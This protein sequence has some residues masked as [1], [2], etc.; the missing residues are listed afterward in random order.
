M[1]VRR[2]SQLLATAVFAVAFVAFASLDGGSVAKAQG[3]Y[4]DQYR[5]HRNYDYGRNYLDRYQRQERREFR[6]RQQ[7]ERYLYGNPPA[8]RYYQ[9]RNPWGFGGYPRSGRFG[10]YGGFGRFGAYPRW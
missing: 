9:R 1:L 5:D 10:F 8:P 6:R 2:L 4:H 3:R 7:I